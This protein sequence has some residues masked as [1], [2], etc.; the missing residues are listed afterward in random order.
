MSNSLASD[1]GSKVDVE[2]LAEGILDSDVAFLRVAPRDAVAMAQFIRD[3]A[4]IA[5]EAVRFMAILNN[6]GDKPRSVQT[7]FDGMRHL[8]ALEKLLIKSGYMEVHD[9]HSLPA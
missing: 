9:D 4:A 6:L 1:G 5:N 2:A 8:V 3:H 7:R